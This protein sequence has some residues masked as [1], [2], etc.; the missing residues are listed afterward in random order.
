MGV[1]RKKENELKAS[2]LRHK[3]DFLAFFPVELM[4]PLYS[5]GITQGFS[6]CLVFGISYCQGDATGILHFPRAPQTSVSPYGLGGLFWWLQT[7]PD[8]PLSPASCGTAKLP[9]LGMLIWVLGAFR[10]LAPGCEGQLA[11]WTPFKV[12]WQSSFRDKFNKYV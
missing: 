3:I 5:H 6:W 1:G 9:H 4:W 10:C 2:P 12:P 8:V 11:T 7:L